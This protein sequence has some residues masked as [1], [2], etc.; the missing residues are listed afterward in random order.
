MPWW[1]RMLR[2][3]RSLIRACMS[4]YPITDPCP[5]CQACRDA[6]QFGA[7][8]WSPQLRAYTMPDLPWRRRKGVGVTEPYSFTVCPWCGGDLV[9]VRDDGEGGE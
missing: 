4:G 7:L 9:T 3:A 2:W 6:V 8:V 1:R 5:P